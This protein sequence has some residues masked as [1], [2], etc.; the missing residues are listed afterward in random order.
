[1]DWYRKTLQPQ[2]NTEK[3]EAKFLQ[4]K[5]ALRA[6]Q[7]LTRENLTRTVLVTKETRKVL[8]SSP[9]VR[10]YALKEDRIS[11]FLF[12]LFRK[13]DFSAAVLSIEWFLLLVLQN[14]KAKAQIP[15]EIVMLAAFEAQLTVFAK[16]SMNKKLERKR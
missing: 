16:A 6:S 5:S 8:R 1:M 11:E 3:T 10:R 14:K 2:K 9:V 12:N 4:R 15:Y 13:R 7:F